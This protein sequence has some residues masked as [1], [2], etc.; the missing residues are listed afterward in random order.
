[1]DMLGARRIYTLMARVKPRLLLDIMAPPDWV[2]IAH[3]LQGAVLVDMGID[4][5]ALIS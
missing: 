2:W 1:M 3:F 4:P 5:G